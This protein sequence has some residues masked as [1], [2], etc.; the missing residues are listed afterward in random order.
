MEVSEIDA[1]EVDYAVT[2]DNQ[3]YCGDQFVVHTSSKLCCKYRTK[4]LYANMP[5][6]K[7]VFSYFLKCSI[8]TNSHCSVQL[9]MKHTAQLWTNFF[10]QKNVVLTENN[11]HRFVGSRARN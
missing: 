6:N 4:M 8:I 1:G 2:D 10:S 9:M 7:M 3:T 11:L 5:K